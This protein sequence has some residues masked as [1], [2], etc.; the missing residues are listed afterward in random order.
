MVLTI[1]TGTIMIYVW[2]GLIIFAGI[3]EASTMDLT[4]IWFSVGA[5]FALIVAI[6]LPDY[7][8][9]Q[10]VIF[11]IVSVL[12]L[13]GLRPLF[14]EYI[15]K[16]EI[17]TNSDKLIGKIAI[18]TKAILDGERGEVKIDGKIW[19]AIANEDI[20][21]TEKVEVLS[22]DGVKLVVRKN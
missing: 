5:F 18:C 17:K 13:L 14:R 4:S 10:V 11:I 22:I 8:I 7:I 9:L 6:F 15:R 16:N 1:E 21:L 2:F 12:L 3:I 20:Q 19:T